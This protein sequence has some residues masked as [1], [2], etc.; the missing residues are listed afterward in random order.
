[1]NSHFQELFLL[2]PD[3]TFLNHG[4]FGACP[5]PVHEIYQNWQVQLERQP[6]KFLGRD[7]SELMRQSRSELAEFLKVKQ[8]DI[9][10]FTNPTTA[11]NML[12]R[13]LDLQP[14]DEV[15]A[16]NHEY[17]A[18][19]RAWRYIC[20]Q[21]S[22][23][24]IN[25]PVPLPLKSQDS[26]ADLF[27]S[28]VTEKTKVIFLSHITSQSALIFPV[29]EI[30]RHA[31]QAGI[32]TIIDG[33]HAPGQIDLDLTTIG[34]D[35]YIGALHKWFC[36]PKGASFLYASTWL[37]PKL[38]PLV[39]SWGYE[40]DSPGP[41]RFI[42]YHE[43]QGTRDPAAFLS[44]PAAIRFQK[45][46]NWD[47]VRRDCHLLAAE[48][49]RR[50][51]ALTG[52]EPFCPESGQWFGQMCSIRLPSV[53]LTVLKNKLYDEFKIEVPVFEWNHIPMMRVSFQA[54]NNQRDSQALLS[55]LESLLPQL[56]TS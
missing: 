48:T 1:M 19:D 17:G 45:E 11:A 56:M 35:A 43:W 4:S 18:M 16:T 39:V 47:Q 36:A 24:Y 54:Y 51:N 3:I 5:R 10:F 53:D 52:F 12:V 2:D 46:N 23:S 27:W 28:G 8:D 20:K 38:D 33:A 37:Q 31:R 9:V 44:V 7:F 34:A 50:I 26:I 13:N 14:G 32:L 55:A 15:L 42:D 22:A 49:R 25:L 30:C 21:R 40:S 29:A 41:S 6:V